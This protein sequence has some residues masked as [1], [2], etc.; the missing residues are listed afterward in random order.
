MKRT[1]E[2]EKD[3]KE[4][5]DV[6][7]KMG[8]RLDGMGYTEGQISEEMF[9]ENFEMILN[10][11][12][13]EIGKVLTNKISYDKNNKKIAEFD[14]IGVNGT[15]VFLG[16]VKTKLTKKHIDKF[17]EKTLP[18]FNNYA[19]TQKY[20]G[21][22]I[23]GIMGARTFESKEIKKYAINKGLYLMTQNNYGATKILKESIKGA[24]SFG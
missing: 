22:K 23:F 8:K 6:M 18:E 14:I 13:E 20:R 5:R 2:N 16:E 3:I 10:E 4:L 7:K 11:G 12:G 19:K 24:I 15:K 1:I 17:L 21:L 9:S